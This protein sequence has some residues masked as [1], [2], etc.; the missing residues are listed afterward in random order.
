MY[1]IGSVKR[2]V[3][4]GYVRA[5]CPLRALCEINAFSHGDSTRR[6]PAPGME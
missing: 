3:G 2:E 4:S 5:L 6:V 1:E